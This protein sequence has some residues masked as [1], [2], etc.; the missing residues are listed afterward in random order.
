LLGYYKEKR[1][2]ILAT[3]LELILLHLI[4]IIDLYNKGRGTQKD[5]PYFCMLI[6]LKVTFVGCD[7]GEDVL[8]LAGAL[9]MLMKSPL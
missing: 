3:H 8:H 4:H 5:I 9:D 7:I 1:R 2:E 6:V